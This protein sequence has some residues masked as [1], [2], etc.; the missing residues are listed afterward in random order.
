VDFNDGSVGWS[1]RLALRRAINQGTPEEVA[2]TEGSHT[3]R[4]LRRVL[5]VYE[6]ER[7]LA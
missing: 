5:P 4:F 3:G 2:E 7:A 6:P 1:Q